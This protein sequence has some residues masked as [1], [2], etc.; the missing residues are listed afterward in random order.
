MGMP[1]R[2]DSDCENSALEIS[3]QDLR[4]GKKIYR[5]AKTTIEIRNETSLHMRFCHAGIAVAETWVA[6]G[7]TN[8][9]N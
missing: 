9:K 3:R 1:D 6:G 4:P 8:V 2:L 7:I 5:P